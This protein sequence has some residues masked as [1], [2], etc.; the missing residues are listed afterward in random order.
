MNKRPETEIADLD[1]Q[2]EVDVTIVIPIYNEEGILSAS[3]AD[4]TEKLDNDPRWNNSYQIILAENGSTDNTIA[5][6]KELMERHPELEL[7]HNPEPDYGLALRRGILAAKG[8]YVICDEIDLCDTDFYVR[9]LGKMRDEGFDL[10]VGSKALKESSDRRPLYRRLATRVLNSLL[11]IFLGFKGTDTHGLKAFKRKRLLDVIDRCVVNKD[12]FA[13]E[14]VIRAE[15]MNFR[16]TEIPLTVVEKRQ[17]S[18]N[19][20]RRVPNVL[21]NLARLVWVIRIRHRQ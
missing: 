10:V 12:L 5:V 6:A 19:L 8:E 11:H 7:M 21:K 16:M 18:I 17:P 1:E 3:I 15:R 4:L 13:S 9:A 14:F 20:F 2:R